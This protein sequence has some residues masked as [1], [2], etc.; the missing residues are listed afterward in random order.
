VQCWVNAYHPLADT[1]DGPW[2]NVQPALPRFADASCRREPDL[3]AEFPAITGLCRPYALR[4]FNKDDLIA[5]FTVKR[6]Y[7]GEPSH[8]RSTAVLRV[9]ESCRSHAGAGDWYRARSQPLPRNLMLPG[10]PP[11]PLSE[12]EGFYRREDQNGE[13]VRVYSRGPDD[14]ER[15][16]REWDAIYAERRGRCQDVRVCEALFR[17]I[18]DG[19]VMNDDAVRDVFRGPFPNTELRP[20]RV[21]AATMHRLMTWLNLSIP[22]DL[23][24]EAGL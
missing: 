22:A 18:E 11:L 7:F 8:W 12:T 2:A 17:D 19:R 21:P 4:K 5:Y 24:G 1:P 14:D 20:Q 23:A 13:E 6:P 16:V 3:G 9:L 15:V 10:N